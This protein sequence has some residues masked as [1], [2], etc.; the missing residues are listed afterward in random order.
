MYIWRAVRATLGSTQRGPDRSGR[1]GG[2]FAQPAPWRSLSATAALASK[3]I[4]GTEGSLLISNSP[5]A[6]PRSTTKPSAVANSEV[7][8]VSSVAEMAPGS[9]PTD[10]QYFDSIEHRNNQ[11]MLNLRVHDSPQ[12]PTQI[13][14][15][16]VHGAQERLTRSDQPPPLH[17]KPG[18]LAH[19]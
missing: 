18:T 4:V 9:S 14:G 13:L 19:V 15:D 2:V 10:T 12:A 5:V 11:Q 16:Q 17:P 3:W 7:R 1:V 8:G 6:G